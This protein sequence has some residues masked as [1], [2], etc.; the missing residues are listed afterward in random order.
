MDL[1]YRGSAGYGRDC[2]TAIYRNMGGKDI[3]SAVVAARWLAEK[4]GIDPRRIGIYGGSYG[5]FFTLMA[6]FKHPGVFAAGAALFPVTDWSH[7][8]HPYTSN[9]LN[10]PYEDEEAYRRSSPIYHAAGLQDRLLILHGMEDRNVHYQDTVR[11][12]QRLIEL[13]KTGWELA[14]MPVED[15]GWRNEFSRLDSN[16]RIFALFEEVLKRPLP[17]IAESKTPRKQQ[18]VRAGNN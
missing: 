7:Y 4:Q 3:D 12:I 9:I 1:D 5:G 18:S 17:A 11:L 6:Q 13:K 15:H 16:R 2:R 8:N 14:T 10:L